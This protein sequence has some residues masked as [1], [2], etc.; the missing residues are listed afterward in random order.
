MSIDEFYNAISRARANF[1]PSLP[2][3]E[4]IRSLVALLPYGAGKRLCKDIGIYEYALSRFKRG[5]FAEMKY[6]T[7]KA[8]YDWIIKNGDRII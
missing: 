1:G 7:L 8:I 4:D 5:H 2:D 3:P 6:S